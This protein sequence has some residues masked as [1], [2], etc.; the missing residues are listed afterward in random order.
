VRGREVA[1]W[2]AQHCA[3]LREPFL[4]GDHDGF[5]LL[6]FFFRFAIERL[7]HLGFVELFAPLGD[8]DGRDAIADQVGQGARF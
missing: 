3:S 4:L 1:R 8:N 2:R 6:R 7:L 5:R